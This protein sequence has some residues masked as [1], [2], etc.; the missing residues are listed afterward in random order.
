MAGGIRREIR[1]GIA[2]LTLAREEVRNA[3]DLPMLSDLYEGLGAAAD[4]RDVHLVLLDAE[5]PAFCAG[6]NLR[7]VDLADTG[8]AE[9]FA[10]ALASVYLRMMTLP[11][12]VLCAVDGPVS[13][14]GVGLVA[15]SDLVWAGE[16]ARFALPETR[17]GLV[18]ALVSVPL[19]RR[20][21]LGCVVRMGLGGTFLDAARATGEGLADVRVSGD[22]GPI[23]LEAAGALLRDH[24]PGALSRT[25]RFLVR[26][27]RE[28][29]EAD[30]DSATAEFVE[31]VGTAEARRGLETFRRKESVRWDTT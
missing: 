12:P 26:G 28:E 22:A 5:G 24:A 30:L 25:K 13:G 19:R 9:A 18:P 16:G 15:A 6:M 7:S 27:A 3:L 21:G 8:Q 11:K 2:R 4:S 1:D 23:A 14:G 31:A 10:H 29:M 20:V 17:L